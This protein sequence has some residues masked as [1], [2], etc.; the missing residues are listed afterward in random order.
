[1]TRGKWWESAVKSKI[2]DI[3]I[4]FDRRRGERC[5]AGDIQ[6]V[7]KQAME[8]LF[9]IFNNFKEDLSLSTLSGYFGL[10]Q[11]YLGTVIKS[12]LGMTFLDFLQSLRMKYACSLLV[13]TSMPVT[14]I[15]YSSGYQSYRNFV[16]FFNKCYNMNP[17]QFRMQRGELPDGMRAS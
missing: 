4:L 8:I 7:N 6:C 12:A 3:L 15:A 11:N 1:M 5:A 13:S 17:S 9:Y 16:R 10:S 14:D 2:M